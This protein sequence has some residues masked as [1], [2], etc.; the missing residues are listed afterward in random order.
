M[1]TGTRKAPAP[2]PVFTS[3]DSS[4]FTI[5]QI[6]PDYVPPARTREPDEYDKLVAQLGGPGPAVELTIK[7]DAVERTVRALQRAATRA[8]FT[9]GWNLNSDN[10][11]QAV[12]M[13]RLKAPR[14]GADSE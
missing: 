7:S 9:G 10:G 6:V 3:G 13:F 12:G 1:A 2:T 4:P 8:G 14:A 11:G 5:G